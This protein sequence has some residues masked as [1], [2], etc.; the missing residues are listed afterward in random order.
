M[1]DQCSRSLPMRRS[2]LAVPGSSTKMLAK[3]QGLP[4][5]EVFFDLEDSV[6]ASGKEEARDNVIQALRDGDWGDKVLSVRVNDCTTKWTYRDITAV[7]GSA[8]EHLDTVMIP[9]VQCAGQVAFVDHLVTQI[10]MDAGWDVGRIGLEFQMEDAQGLV[11]ARSILSESNRAE[12]LILGPGDMAAALGMPSLTI[13]E[14][15][16]SYPGDRWH[17]A[18]FTILVEARNAGVQAIDGPYAKIR[19]LDGLRESALRSRS[20]GFDGKWVLH[21]SQ[22]AEV[23][24]I[25]SEDQLDYERAMDILE[26]FSVAV[27]EEQRGAVAF[28]DE[29]IDEA[30]RKLANSLVE[31]AKRQGVEYRPAPADVPPHERA[32]WRRGNL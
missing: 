28:G 12:T 7:V 11:N 13:G 18:L 16:S 23:N 19:D 32:A 4:A 17:W 24:A 31:K 30:S 20:L 10:E 21:P 29:M 9:K 15:D 14:L 25:Y 1:N 27:T 22:I 2:T 8:G 26:A 5:D 3:A 6:P